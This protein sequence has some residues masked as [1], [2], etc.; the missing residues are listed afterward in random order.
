MRI[1]CAYAPLVVAV[2]FLC[3]SAVHQIPRS[4]SGRIIRSQTARKA[5][6]MQSGHLRGR[7]GYVIDHVIALKRGGCDEPRNMQWQ[8]IE[9][10]REK[11]RWE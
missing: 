3:Y 11:D 9:D 10:A 8:T 6:M 4:E 2:G 7:T 5:F 1:E